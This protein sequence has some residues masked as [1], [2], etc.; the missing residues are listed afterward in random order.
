MAAYRLG[1]DLNIVTCGLTD[2]TPGSALGPTLG[3]EYGRTLPFSLVIQAEEQKLEMAS[4]TSTEFDSKLADM[5]REMDECRG[6][7]AR[8]KVEASHLSAALRE[9]EATKKSK[10]RQFAELQQ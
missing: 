5:R 6:E 3:Y 1:V 10:D 8:V 9:A 4:K 7:A 2:C